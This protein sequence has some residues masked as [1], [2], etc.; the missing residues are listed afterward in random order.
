[1]HEDN[2]SRQSTFHHENKDDQISVKDV[3]GSWYKSEGESPCN[4]YG[5][6]NFT[7]TLY[8][9]L[10][11]HLTC[12]I[13]GLASLVYG[14]FSII[15]CVYL[16]SKFAKINVYT[17]TYSISFRTSEQKQTVRLV[18]S[19]HVRCPG[20]VQFLNLLSPAIY[21]QCR[22]LKEYKLYC[23]LMLVDIFAVL[24]SL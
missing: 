11:Y 18:L 1:M 12:N 24:F 13:S 5:S 14:V 10:W 15:K 23:L 16:I 20:N 8:C 21:T 17:S 6:L 19:G 4:K 2:G 9:D 3:W 22:S 7:F